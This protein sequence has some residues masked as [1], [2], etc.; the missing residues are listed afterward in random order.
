MPQHSHSRGS[1][2][3]FNGRLG[4]IPSVESILDGTIR[5][6]MGSGQYKNCFIEPMPYSPPERWMESGHILANPIYVMISLCFANSDYRG[7][8]MASAPRE[9]FDSRGWSYNDPDY[10]INGDIGG[11][12]IRYEKLIYPYG[13]YSPTSEARAVI[14]AAENLKAEIES[15]YRGL[16]FVD[17]VDFYDLWINRETHQRY[18]NLLNTI[19]DFKIKP[20]LFDLE[21]GEFSN[22]GHM[23][24]WWIDHTSDWFPTR[25][26]SIHIG[27][28]HCTS[29]DGSVSQQMGDVETGTFFFCPTPL[30]GAPEDAFYL[31]GSPEAAMSRY[32]ETAE[33]FDK[34][35]LWLYLPDTATSV[36]NGIDYGALEIPM[37]RSFTTGVISGAESVAG[38]AGV[39]FRGSPAELSDTNGMIEKISEFFGI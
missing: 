34:R 13:S 16:V 27:H 30:A 15:V 5:V 32:L 10:Y 8:D 3:L 2:P 9:F 37:I 24:P 20:V 26:L 7:Y 29:R 22:I 35:G 14:E 19:N 6:C 31:V 33:R 1:V 28:A 18:P 36:W 11:L 38:D 21:K 12:S 17:I 25:F 39:S 4:Q 23:V